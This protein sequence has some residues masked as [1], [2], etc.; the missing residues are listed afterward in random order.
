[1]HA[2]IYIYMGTGYEK[3]F[4][5][6]YPTGRNACRFLS[7]RLCAYIQ[8][9]TFTQPKKWSSSLRPATIFFCSNG[10]SACMNSVARYEGINRYA[11]THALTELRN[12]EKLKLWKKRN[13]SESTGNFFTISLRSLMALLLCRAGTPLRNNSRRNGTTPYLIAWG[14]PCIVAACGRLVY[15]N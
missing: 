3:S 1:M 11:H 14:I 8:N 15:H 13:E 4:Y 2:Y 7:T 9:H 5:L 6:K 12:N 10:T